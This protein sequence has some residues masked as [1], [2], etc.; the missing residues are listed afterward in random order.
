MRL[1]Y[2]LLSSALFL[3]TFPMLAKNPATLPGTEPLTWEGDLSARMVDGI[4]RFLMRRLERSVQRR[5]QHWSREFSSAEAYQRSVE[6]NRRHFREIIGVVEERQRPR[7]EYFGVH[8]GSPLV[9]ETNR[10]RVLQV[11]WDVLD[12]IHGEGLLLE[13]K[14]APSASVVALADADQTP[15]QLV[16]LSPGV[17]ADSQFARRLAEAG[18][19]VIVP[20]LISRSSQFSGNPSLHTDGLRMTNMPHR[21]WLYRMAY[22]MG[23]HLI[24]YEVQKVLAAVDWLQEVSGETGRIGVAGYAEGGLIALYSAAADPRIDACLV[25]GYF[26]PRE[27]VW[28]EPIYR[29]VWSLLD[30]F[31]DAEIASLVL[32]RDLVIEYSP[33]PEF[34][35]RPPAREWQK[36]VAAPGRLSTPSSDAVRREFG[37]LEE[38]QKKLP[39][40]FKRSAHLVPAGA[41]PQP[42]K[43]GSDDALKRFVEALT[44]GTSPAPHS[45]PSPAVA[46]DLRA[47]F[48]PQARQRR[49]V[50]EIEDHLQDFLRVSSVTRDKFFL[51]KVPYGSAAQFAEAAAEYR[52]YFWEEVIG[53]VHDPRLP[54]NTRSRLRYE[55]AKWTG[56]DVVLDVWP[57]V[58][59]WGILLL[60][61]DLRPGEKRPVVVAQHGLEGLP[62]DVI[63]K[64]SPSF[65][66]YR[67][68]AAR[69]AERGFIVFAPHNPYRGQDKF[70]VLQFKA[71][72]LKLSLFSF[73]VGQH[74]QI[75]DW[76]KSLPH[77]DGER[78]AFYG[79]SYGG[80]TAMRVPAIV[81]GYGLSICS[82]DFNEWIWKN[83]TIDWPRSYMFTKEYE[84]PDFKL[85]ITFNYAE[86]AYLI[87]PRPFMVE[88]GH[89]DEVG[90]DEWVAHEY[91]KIRRLYNELG[92]GDRTEIEFFDGEHEINGRGTF[93]FLHKHLK[94][95]TP[96]GA[97]NQ[98]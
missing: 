51:E 98:Q 65:Q 8:P 61:R 41:S 1:S 63:E 23:R 39:S 83:V 76:L 19:R 79:L 17:E 12:G 5:Q 75:V 26:G 37:R 16:G 68:F 43:P 3:F 92:V 4:D 30:E 66:A 67:A 46:E 87:F 27:G 10:Y 69:L 60:P 53:K 29:N 70:R 14:G 54:A 9:A 42:V 36:N 33:T 77:V 15:E 95:P 96:Q 72:P 40:P 71:N 47:G 48:D 97:S 74:L 62:S 94:W 11:R 64:A 50:R 25:S 57:E 22:E 82:A 21:E 13:P 91:A 84:M 44:A 81:Q 32:P 86:M 38:W 93:E 34:S 58:F 20:T 31:G 45:W 89:R 18:L 49:Q 59:A 80:K 24:G 56:Y 88:R 2:R 78:I 35:G 6:P 85:G 73:I 28:G 55:R 90:L 52:K 7:V